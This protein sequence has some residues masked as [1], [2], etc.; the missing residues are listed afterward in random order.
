MIKPEEYKSLLDFNTLAID[1][2]CRYFFEVTLAEHIPDAIAFAEQ[3]QLPWLVLGGGSNLVF[4]QDYPGVIIKNALR[5]VDYCVQGESVLV[6]AAAGES[7]HQ[8]VSDSLARGYGGLENLALIAGSVGAAAVQNIGAYGV[9][10]EQVFES[11]TVW[12]N[13]SKCWQRLTKTDCQFAYR[14]SVFKHALKGCGVITEICLQLHSQIK[15]N[16]SYG[17]LNERLLQ[18]GIDQP[19]P[20]QVAAAVMEI[21][22]EKLPDPA[23]LP[24]AGSFFKNP[25]IEQTHYARLQSTYPQLPRYA[26]AD[27]MVKVPAGW[28]LEEAGW[29]GKSLGSF[30]MHK[31]QALVLVHRGGGTGSELLEF[32]EQIKEDI[33]NR[34]SIKLEIEPS[35]Y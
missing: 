1:V 31:A 21:R 19:T 32:A 14:D 7:W 10:L 26:A 8:L 17:A 30:G 6:S 4:S 27:G 2:N 18:H 13:R 12:D 28:L 15:V 33:Y 5:G 20:K 16:T 3:Q 29:K 35:V 22:Q 9:E 23:V 25:L 34:F 24:N 11:L